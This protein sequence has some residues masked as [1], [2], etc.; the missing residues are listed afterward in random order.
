ME[1]GLG[2]AQESAFITSSQDADVASSQDYAVGNKALYGM[3]SP[4]HLAL[5]FSAFVILLMLHLISELH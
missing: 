4:Y 1:K 3:L 2:G 5:Y